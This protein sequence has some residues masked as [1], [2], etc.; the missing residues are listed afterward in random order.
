M[1]PL[2]RGGAWWHGSGAHRTEAPGRS[3]ARRDWAPRGTDTGEWTDRW[4]LHG[5]RRLPLLGQATVSAFGVNASFR[6][7]QPH[8]NRLP[9]NWHSGDL[10]GEVPAT[11]SSRHGHRRGG[12]QRGSG[13]CST[14]PGVEV[15]WVSVPLK[16]YSLQRS[17]L[18]EK[19]FPH[20]VYRSLVL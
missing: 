9:V 5:P 19:C 6:H 7:N 18:N 11:A 13:I 16:S 17:T 8:P 20:H 15:L 10:E 12:H 14:R 3:E 1:S 2:R 4:E